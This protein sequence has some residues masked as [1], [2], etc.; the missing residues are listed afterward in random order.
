[1]GLSGV[2]SLDEIARAASATEAQARA[3]AR[4]DGPLSAADAVRLGRALVERR[5]SG[6]PRQ[7]PLFYAASQRL[8][9]E[10]RG[11]PLALSG[12]LHVGAL[13]AIA[14]AVSFHATAATTAA[15]EH[16]PRVSLIFFAIPGPGGGG[17]GGGRLAKTPPSRVA[18]KGRSALTSPAPPQPTVT[19]AQL[20]PAEPLAS[21]IVAPIVRAP[22]DTRD[23]AGVLEQIETSDESAGSGRGGGAG[24]GAGTG[25][26][27]G[28]G[29]GIGPGVGGG[30]GG[31]AYRPG[32]GITPPRLVHEVK[33]DYTEE[34][35]RRGLTGEVLM[36]IVV[37]H[38]GSVGNVRLLHGLGLGLDER[39]VA[40]VRQWRFAPAH[41]QGVAVD[42][43]VEAGMEF[44]L[45]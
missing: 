44:K 22:D 1:M 21:T 31:G 3:L 36:E 13:A 42:V 33:G 40:A 24:T 4:V 12:S 45:R 14:L 27:E 38:D 18:F 6:I 19:A 2:Y 41:R 5:R 15:V 30:F 28:D 37:R 16:G 34:A 25:I 35:R 20:I 43:I 7:A 10:G 32:S 29:T 26:G 39:A 11:G 23:R 8:S 17:G 9:R